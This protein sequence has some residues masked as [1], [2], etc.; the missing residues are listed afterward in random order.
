MTL[1]EIIT[2]FVIFSMTSTLLFQ[3]IG[4]V[5]LL[6]KKNSLIESAAHICSNEIEYMKI[7]GQYSDSLIDDQKIVQLHNRDF[8]ISRTIVVDSHRDSLD[9]GKAQLIDLKIFE[10]QENENPLLHIRFIQGKY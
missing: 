9:L 2:A 1:I 8:F 4:Y 7:S 5:D 6:Y 3:F 10:S